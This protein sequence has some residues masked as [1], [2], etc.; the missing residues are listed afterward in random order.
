MTDSLRPLALVTGAFSG[1]GLEL[2]RQSVREW[3]P[4]LANALGAKPPRRAPRWMARLFA[5]S[6]AAGCPSRSPSRGASSS[7]GTGSS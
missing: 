5:G 1:I 4:V 2:A 7:Q 3:L 6:A